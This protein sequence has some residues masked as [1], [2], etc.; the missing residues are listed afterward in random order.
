MSISVWT[1][2]MGRRWQAKAED[3]HVLD[4][5]VKSGVRMF[6]P[7]WNSV[8]SYKNHEIGELE[9]ANRYNHRMLRSQ[10]TNPEAWDKILTAHPRVALAC[11]CRPGAFCHRHLF[12]TLMKDYLTAKNVE[13]ID[14][15]EL[16]PPP[17]PPM[18]SSE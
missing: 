18:E 12:R 3:I 15:G 7:D 4:I 16:V 10:Q 1:M 6:A 17:P 2:Q 8:L 11:Y 13:V 9:Y 5:T 14:M